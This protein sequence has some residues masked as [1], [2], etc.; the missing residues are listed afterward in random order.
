MSFINILNK[1]P[2]VAVSP[3]PLLEVVSDKTQLDNI[4][5]YLAY[6]LGYKEVTPKDILPIKTETTPHVGT[7]AEAIEAGRTVHS[8]SII[9]ALVLRAC[10][11]QHADA[12]TPYVLSITLHNLPKND[13]VT[14]ALKFRIDST[15]HINLLTENIKKEIGD[16]FQTNRVDYENEHALCDVVLYTIAEEPIQH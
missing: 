2:K 1:P 7:I 6:Q 5:E 9:D 4:K 15:L 14:L 13:K 16:F 12:S 11:A 10:N 8:S 3:P